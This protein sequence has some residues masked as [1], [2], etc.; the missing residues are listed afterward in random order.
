MN[1]INFDVIISIPI[2]VWKPLTRRPDQLGSNDKKGGE[3]ECQTS[4]GLIPSF[5]EFSQGFLILK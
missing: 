3:R 2:T 4:G 5:L 1:F